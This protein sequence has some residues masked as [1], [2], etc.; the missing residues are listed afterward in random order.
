LTPFPY[1]AMATA[2]LLTKFG[3]QKNH[4]QIQQE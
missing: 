1:D 3:K 2:M 4:S